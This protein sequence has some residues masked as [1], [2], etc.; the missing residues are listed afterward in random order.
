MWD[1]AADIY[2][3]IRVNSNKFVEYNHL[4][5]KADRTGN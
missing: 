4:Y 5:L 2:T 1:L 3:F